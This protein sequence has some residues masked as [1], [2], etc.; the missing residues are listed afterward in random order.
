MV[1]LSFFVNKCAM[2]LLLYDVR[3]TCAANMLF[4]IYSYLLLFDNTRVILAQREKEMITFKTTKYSY[5]HVSIYKS[6][7]SEFNFS[8]NILHFT[9]NFLQF[10]TVFATCILYRLFNCPTT[11][12][13]FVILFL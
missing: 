13:P 8:E 3:D 1:H 4:Y 7:I 9:Y 6:Y 2:L 11:S 12:I 5:A 10:Y